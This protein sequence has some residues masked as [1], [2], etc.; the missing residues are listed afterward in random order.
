MIDYE[1]NLAL[2]EPSDKNFL[3]GLQPLE[4]ALDTVVGDRLSAWQL[5]ATGALVV[6]EGLVTTIGITRYPADVADF[7]T[8]RLSIPMQYRDNS[9]TVPLV[10]EQQ[11]GRAAPPLRS[12][13]AGARRHPG[14]DHR[15]FPEGCGGREIPGLPVVRH[16]LFPDARSAAARLRRRD[17]EDGRR[18]HHSVEPGLPAAKAGLASRR[19]HHRGRAIT[20]SI[21][22]ETTSIA[23]YGKIEF[24]N[25]LDRE[26]IRRRLGRA[27]RHA[28][29]QAADLERQARASRGRRL[30]RPA[31]QHR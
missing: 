20:T 5:E 7:L 2:I 10:K 14:A 17:G 25:L 9:Y 31:L 30:R 6:T 28:R 19:H 18:L 12:A 23:L 22:T 4:L 29:G 13:L 15:A 3:E 16:F 27:P 1:A 8:Y 26:G 11:A 24:S 21:R